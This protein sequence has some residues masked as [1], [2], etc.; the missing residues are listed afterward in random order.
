MKAEGPKIANPA[1]I[2]KTL[3]NDQV[4]TINRTKAIM[5][6]EKNG[7]TLE[8]DLSVKYEGIKYLAPVFGH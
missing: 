7:K 5:V 2:W 6:A 1:S 4:P 3:K 8:T